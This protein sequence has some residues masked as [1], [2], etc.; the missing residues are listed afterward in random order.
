MRVFNSSCDRE[1]LILASLVIVLTFAFLP[2]QA[3]AQS[4]GKEAPMKYPVSYR[5]TQVDGLSI[6]YREA[7][8]KDAP[9][10][11][12]LR[13]SLLLTNVRASVRAAFR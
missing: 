13:T 11:L 3:P 2:I 5:T 10:L 1:H 9:T 7:G 8:L 12:L 4:Q 6:F